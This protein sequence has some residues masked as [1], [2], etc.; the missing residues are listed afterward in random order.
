[1]AAESKRPEEKHAQCLIAAAS[2]AQGQPS[3]GIDQAPGHLVPRFSRIMDTTAFLSLPPPV[4]YRCASDCFAYVSTRVP[5]KLNNSA[6][7]RWMAVARDIAAAKGSESWSSQAQALLGP[8]KPFL[9]RAYDRFQIWI[10]GRYRLLPTAVGTSLWVDE[11]PASCAPFRLKPGK[12]RLYF[13]S[14]SLLLY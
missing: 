1:M 9:Q 4:V 3:E 5:A 10:E 7:Q 8:L 12:H 6:A 14:S 2:H 11:R 13:H